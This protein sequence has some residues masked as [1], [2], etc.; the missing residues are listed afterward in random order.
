MKKL[1]ELLQLQPTMLVCEPKSVSSRAVSVHFVSPER[2][3]KKTSNFWG[4]SRKKWR[5][6]KILI[7]IVKFEPYDR[8]TVL[9]F[10][11]LLVKM[12]VH[13]QAFERIPRENK[14]FWQLMEG[15]Y[16]RWQSCWNKQTTIFY[17]ILN[18]EFWGY[19]TPKSV[20]GLLVPEG[21]FKG[22]QSCNKGKK[23]F[24]F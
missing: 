10:F 18:F 13:N 24:I 1:K 22:L 20:R 8:G 15:S 21:G 7:F 2:R 17:F 9:A 12:F 5:H 3:L 4:H 11:F 14:Y 6:F 23:S 16:C 19:Q